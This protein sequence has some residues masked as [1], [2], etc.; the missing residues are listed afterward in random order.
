V[1]STTAGLLVL[2]NATNA[3]T[4]SIRGTGLAASR[5]FDLPIGDPAAGQLLSGS[6]SGSTITLSWVSA[7]TNP[8]DNVGQLIYG[9][10]AGVPTKLAA[11]LVSAKRFLTS[12]GIGGVGQAPVW[13]TVSGSDLSSVVPLSLGGTATALT[14]PASNRIMGWDNATSSMAFMVI[15]AGLTYNAATKTISVDAS[16]IV[17]SV[18][19][20]VNRITST[21]GSNPVID[22]SASYIGQASIVT[23]GT[24][25][26]GDWQAG[27]ID[28]EFGGTG[29]DVSTL[30]IGNS[31][32]VSASNEWE[33][34]TPAAGGGSV[35]TVSVVSAN[36]FAGTVANASTTPAITLTTSISGIL[37]GNGTAIS[38]AT[39]GTDYVA[40]GAITTSGLTMATARLLGRTTASTGA[41]EEL[42]VT[43]GLTL[44][45][46]TLTIDST[47]VT[48][49][50]SQTLTNKTLTAPKVDWG[51]TAK[52]ANYTITLND[53]IINCTSNSFTLTFPTAVGIAGRM[54]VVKNRGAGII[55]LAGDSGQTFD[56]VASPTISTDVSMTLLSD[57]ANWIVA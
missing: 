35:T 38:A 57:G 53:T 40:G 43:T 17:V 52:T 54:F 37:K 25:T 22:I 19:G 23:L 12:T 29:L 2:R 39:A 36:G 56:G 44:A 10:V 34:Y 31:I 6:L 5:I 4:Q 3:F 26:T 45:A 42:T 21:G 14:N 33:E 55:T 13:S 51:Y 27:V 24:I 41:I 50:G 16:G 15:G 30:T 9:G 1:A 8:L 46:G 28:G 48:L 18:A 47:V 20:T 49:T 11:N 7:L 32:R